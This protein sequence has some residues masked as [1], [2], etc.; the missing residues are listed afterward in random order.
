MRPGEGVYICES[1]VVETNILRT[2]RVEGERGRGKRK[3][4]A[5][6]ALPATDPCG[7]DDEGKRYPW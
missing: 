3:A 5:N 2:K 4:R 1:K 7:D 6:A